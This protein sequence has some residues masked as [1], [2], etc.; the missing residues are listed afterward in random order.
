MKKSESE[1]TKGKPTKKYS[2]STSSPHFWWLICVLTSIIVALI[3]FIISERVCCS[4][5]LMN[6]ISVCSVLLSITLS[7]F[8]IQY[9]Y[10]SNNEIHRQFDKINSV[11]DNIKAT[12]ENLAVTNTL[13]KENLDK[14]RETLD[15][16]DI[17]QKQIVNQIS[18]IKN[19]VINSSDIPKNNLKN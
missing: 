7:I 8:A 12:S 19:S 9:T 18:D 16:F 4:E 13:L 10:T 2:L 15:N 17:S 3:S 14:I 5:N 11:A 6:Y 1:H